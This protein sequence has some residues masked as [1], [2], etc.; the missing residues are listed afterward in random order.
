MEKISVVIITKNEEKNI[1]RCIESVRDVADEIIVVDSFSSD[2]TKHICNT[3]NVRFIEHAFEGH[4]QQKN[5]AMEQA[6]YNCILSLDADEAL[7]PQLQKEIIAIKAKWLYDGYMFNRL[8]NYCGAWIKHSGW[9]PDK[10]IRLFKK[11]KATWGGQN[12]HDIIVMAKNST[13]QYVNHTILHYSFY[14]ISQHLQQID[15]FTTIASH[16]KYKKGE[17]VTVVKIII[18][19]LLKFLKHYIIKAGFLDGFYGFV[20]SMNSAHA[21]FSKY[22][23]LK[24]LQNNSKC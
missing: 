14:S 5:W 18:A 4:I 7:S 6:R 24:Q 17:N 22:V 15:S 21:T 8:T 16:E 19:P 3:Y 2:A 13:V 23:K 11:E 12:P 20:I 1:A 10:K 9:Y